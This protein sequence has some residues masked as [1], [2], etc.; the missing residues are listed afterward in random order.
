MV[1]APDTSY[2]PVIVDIETCALDDAAAY[3]DLVEPDS[4]LKDPVKIADS[5]AEKTRARDSK[6]GLD[7]NTG[8]LAALGW[9]TEE[10]GLLAGTCQEDGDEKRLLAEFWRVAQ[11][12]MIITFNGRSFDLPFMLQRSLYLRVPCPVSMELSPYRSGGDNVDLFLRLTYGDKAGICMRQTLGAF[13]RRL[14]IP[15]DDTLK[16]ADIQGYVDAGEWDRVLAHVRDDVM[17]T[18]AIARRVGYVQEPEVLE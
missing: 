3:V 14:G 1:M 4:R 16:G 12:R 8:Q 6:F 2:G 5:I 18:V 11:Y 10:D 7:R 15:H 9:W 17:S 13:C